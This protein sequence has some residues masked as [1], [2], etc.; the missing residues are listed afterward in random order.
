[1][2]LSYDFRANIARLGHDAASLAY[3]PN[4]KKSEAQ[5][6]ILGQ[7]TEKK[8][9]KITVLLTDMG[10]ALQGLFYR[11]LLEQEFT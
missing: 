7:I 5:N 1:M 11:N 10:I 3:V 2:L 9:E 6:F 8:Q 4:I